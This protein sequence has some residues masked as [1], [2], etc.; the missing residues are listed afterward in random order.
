[1]SSHPPGNEPGPE[2]FI[3]TIGDIGV[4]RHWVV[5]PNGTAALPGSQWIARDMSRTETKIPTW[6]IVM[7]II[8]AFFCLIGL[9]FLLAKETVTTGY[10]EVS[11]NSGS[12]YHVTQ[13]PVSHPA[14]VQQIRGLVNQAQSLAVSTG[15]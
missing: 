9:F 6:A 5:T 12:L 4:S 13:L 11:V 14:D 10:V 7:A 2:P 8:F 1:M 3:L 15:I